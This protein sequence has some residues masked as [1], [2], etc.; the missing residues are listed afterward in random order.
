VAQE[1]KKRA[2]RQDGCFLLGGLLAGFDLSRCVSRGTFFGKK[3][4]FQLAKLQNFH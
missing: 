2:F 3:H 4:F 1:Y